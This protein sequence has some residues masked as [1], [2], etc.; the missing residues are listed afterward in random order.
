[1][2]AAGPAVIMARPPTNARPGTPHYAHRAPN[3]ARVDGHVH[4]LAT[5]ALRDLPLPRQAT[6][7]AY[8]R[9]FVLLVHPTSE[10][11]RV[12]GILDVRS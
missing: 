12:P 4:D 6:D 9:T 7:A 11:A 3:D 2:P 1:M 5:R 8:A 10:G